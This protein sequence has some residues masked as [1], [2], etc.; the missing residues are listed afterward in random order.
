M[1]RPTYNAVQHWC[2]H[3][4]YHHLVAVRDTVGMITLKTWYCTFVDVNASLC[5]WIMALYV[6]GDGSGA[7]FA[8]LFEYNSTCHLGITSKD[9]NCMYE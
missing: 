2:T 9:S 6:P 3:W 7:L 1:D 5:R 8:L 4:N